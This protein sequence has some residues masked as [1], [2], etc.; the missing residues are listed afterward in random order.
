[1]KVRKLRSEV[2]SGKWDAAFA[3]PESSALQFLRERGFSETIIQ[4]F[5]KPFFGGVFLERELE[6]SSRMLRF[7]MR[8]FSKGAAA[9][10]AAGMQAVAQQLAARLPPEA[11]HLGKRVISL[12]RG[13]L[14]FESGGSLLARRIVIATDAAAGALLDARVRAPAWRSTCC[15]YYAFDGSLS[16]GGYLML[17]G[18]GLGPVNHAAILSEV[19]PEY[20]PRGQT[21]VCA[22]TAGPTEV[23]GSG[24][25][26]AVRAQM[27]A[28]LKVPGSA[29]RLL[30]SYDLPNALPRPAHVGQD[31]IECD[32]ELAD[33]LYVCGD[34]CGIPSL[35][36]AFDSGVR[37]AQRI[38]ERAA[39]RGTMDWLD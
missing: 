34:H 33:D 37:V 2:V 27:S 8:M 21:L 18:D 19:A 3:A 30:K 17:N 38:V 25:E 36:G 31:L 23:T 35:Q 12:S 6:T 14:L 24:L 28:W 32:P 11:I 5:F 15:F 22:N 9:V 26:A 7:T 20:A 13:R 16:N 39:E 10:P 29:L 1:L 4:R